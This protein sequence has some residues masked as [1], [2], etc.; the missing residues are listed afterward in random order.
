MLRSSNSFA[1]FAVA[2]TVLA[3]WVAGT[4]PP[5]QASAPQTLY[6]IGSDVGVPLGGVTLLHAAPGSQRVLTR[7]GSRT[8][9]GSPM[10]LAVVGTSGEWLAVISAALGN[11]VRG[12][13]HRSKV[14]LVHVPVSL[15]VDLSSR[16][17][18]VWRMGHVLRRFG[19]AVGAPATPTPRGRFAIT[20]K[21]SNFMPS[22]YGC[23]TL[24]L[25]G[26]QTHLAPGW[27]GGDRLAIH[28]GSGIGSAVSNGCLRAAE[29]DMRY[30]MGLLPLGT[31]VVVHD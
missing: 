2:A 14:R 15:E 31:Q 6:S 17:L 16:W 23:C 10:T 27:T 12:F 13:V 4:P 11:R 30:S 8:V 1:A 29:T 18:R 9:F 21:L 3:A 20:D 7:V 22:I 5:A 19:I 28:A 25:S 26:R 24:A